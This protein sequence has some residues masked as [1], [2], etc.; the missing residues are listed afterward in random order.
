MKTC[1]EEDHHG[2]PAIGGGWHSGG[3]VDDHA[4]SP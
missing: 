4:T 1:F 3:V 2:L